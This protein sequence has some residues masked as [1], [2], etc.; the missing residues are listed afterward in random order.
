MYILTIKTTGVN[1]FQKRLFRDTIIFLYFSR[2]SYIFNFN[3]NSLQ[4]FLL[5]PY[6]ISRFNFR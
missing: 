1:I 5:I 2:I 6:H 3:V 4:I